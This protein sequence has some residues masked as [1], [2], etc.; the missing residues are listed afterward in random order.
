LDRAMGF[1]AHSMWATRAR[2]TIS[3]IFT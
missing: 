3:E 2:E 1:A